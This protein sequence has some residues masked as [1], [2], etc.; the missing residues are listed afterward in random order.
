MAP[1]D[2]AEFPRTEI[3]HNIEGVE[4]SGVAVVRVG[5]YKLLQRMQ[6]A[7]GFD[8]W[9]DMC[10][11]TAGCWIPPNAGPGAGV[12]NGT[13]VA[14]GGQLCCFSAPPSD[15]NATSSCLPAFANHSEPLPEF[16]LFDVDADP[17]ERHDLSRATDDH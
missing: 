2:A 17:A 10:N 13:T 6:V 16:L 15:A 14:F 9:C 3:L 1:S 12:P 5:A 4:G 8:G 11:H 7:R